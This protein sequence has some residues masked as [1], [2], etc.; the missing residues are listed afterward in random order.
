MKIITTSALLLLCF[1]VSAQNFT[2][3]NGAIVWQKVYKNPDNLPLQ[4]ITLQLANIT[5]NDAG[6]SGSIT[7]SNVNY[8]AFGIKRMQ[9]PL[10]MTQPFSAAVHIEHKTG[11]YRVTVSNILFDDLDIKIETPSPVG[12]Y[13]INSSGEIKESQKKALA[14]FDQDL[15]S[16]FTIVSQTSQW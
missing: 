14:T 12:D 11:K 10:Y 6:Y 15:T 5:S 9:M 4:P 8:T 3:L 1:A 2:V 7:K 16:R 13:C